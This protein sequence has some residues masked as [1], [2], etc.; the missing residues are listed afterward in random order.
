MNASNRKNLDDLIIVGK[1]G[2]R[3]RHHQR[4]VQKI[5]ELIEMRIERKRRVKELMAK[6]SGTF[7]Q[8]D[9]KL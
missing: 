2:E 6:R 5:N 8:K 9:N 7:Y 3:E 1:I 4:K